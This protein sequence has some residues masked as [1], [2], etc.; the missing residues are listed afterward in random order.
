MNT[1][2][3]PLPEPL[4]VIQASSL[5]VPVPSQLPHHSHYDNRYNYSIISTITRSAATTV[6]LLLLPVALASQL[7][8]QL[9]VKLRYLAAVTLRQVLLFSCAWSRVTEFLGLKVRWLFSL[10]V[11]KYVGLNIG[12]VGL[13]VGYLTGG[14]Q[15]WLLGVVSLNSLG[16][17]V[18]LGEGACWVFDWFESKGTSLGSKVPDLFRCPAENWPCSLL[19]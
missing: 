18:G 2:A 10:I 19:H 8:Q 9:P 16:L 7:P 12:S 5:Q 17:K 14:L 3:I 6:I 15:R 1:T 11:T 4:S 13:S